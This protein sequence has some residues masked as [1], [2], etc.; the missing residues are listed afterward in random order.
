MG[1]DGIG[2]LNLL[3]LLTCAEL[4]I[5]GATQCHPYITQHWTKTI[6]QPGSKFSNSWRTNLLKKPR[7]VKRTSLGRWE[8][9]CV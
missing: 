2:L 9:L 8:N 3:N 4:G 7:G 6:V 1:F 5:T